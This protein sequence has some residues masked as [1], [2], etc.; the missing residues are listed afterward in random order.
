MAYPPELDPWTVT[1]S[2]ALGL[3]GTR[4]DIPGVLDLAG[5]AAHAVAR[6][7]AP[8]TAYL[9]GIAVGRGVP[10]ADAVATVARLTE[11]SPST[12]DS[13]PESS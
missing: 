9:V 6:P 5:H 4:V 2:S 3:D 10:F 1:L 11:G 13:D 8:L 7:A 12:E